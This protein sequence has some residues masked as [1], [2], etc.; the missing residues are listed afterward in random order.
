MGEIMGGEVMVEGPYAPNRSRCK[1]DSIQRHV[2]G[3]TDCSLCRDHIPIAPVLPEQASWALV[4]DH[5]GSWPTAELERLCGL[6]GFAHPFA[7]VYALSCAEPDPIPSQLTWCS[8]HLKNALWAAGVPVAVVAGDWAVAGLGFVD[9][10][11]APVSVWRLAGRVGIWWTGSDLEGV[12]CVFVDLPD[13]RNK[14]KVIDQ[15]HVARRV[16]EG[17][18]GPMDLVGEGGC[19]GFTYNVARCKSY[20]CTHAVTWVDERGLP[21]CNGHRGA[22]TTR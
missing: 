14:R 5:H 22:R 15:L 21:W 7:R 4:T 20:P 1:V 11:G 3:C 19:C 2:S 16:L 18:V 9:G 8:G 12:Y 13:G 10:D 6:V 17:D